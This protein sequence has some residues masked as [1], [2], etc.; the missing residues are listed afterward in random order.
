MKTRL[1]KIILIL[2]ISTV[3][4]AFLLIKPTYASCVMQSVEQQRQRADVVA[5]GTAHSRANQYF[6][7]KIESYYKGNVPKEIKVQGLNSG[8]TGAVTSIDVN[9]KVGQKYLLYLKALQSDIY[10]TNLCMG[11]REFDGTLTDEEKKVL[12][13]A[14]SPSPNSNLVTP[15]PSSSPTS[16]FLLLPSPSPHEY[17]TPP[18]TISPNEVV[19]VP[20]LLTAIINFIRS[21]FRLS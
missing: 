12:E 19:T 4:S 1:I 17:R 6:I 2:I 7:L 10:T 3:F 5:T 8:N 9:F 16:F 15:Y 11:T 20:N 13:P 21:I 14:I 18:S